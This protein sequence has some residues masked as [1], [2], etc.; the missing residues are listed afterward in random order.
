[1]ATEAPEAELSPLFR[2]T[3]FITVEGRNGKT[4]SY[5]LPPEVIAPPTNVLINGALF[6]LEG[7]WEVPAKAGDP[8]TAHY[9]PA[10][11]NWALDISGLEWNDPPTDKLQS[12]AA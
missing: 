1:M 9:V 2:P 3:V 6:A 5:T 11:P 10:A 7:T 4:R 12:E 8:I